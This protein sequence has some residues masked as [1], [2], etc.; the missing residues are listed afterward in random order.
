MDCNCTLDRFLVLRALQ[1]EINLCMKTV[2]CLRM[3]NQYYI[4]F[5]FQG[6][7]ITVREKRNKKSEV[8]WCYV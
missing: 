2:L 7:N 1:F 4:C 6:L 5:D 3:P 8:R